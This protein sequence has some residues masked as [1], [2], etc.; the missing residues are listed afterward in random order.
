MSSVSNN[1]FQILYNDDFFEILQKS[2]N[3]PFRIIKNQNYQ[4]N[5]KKAGY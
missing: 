5:N 2:T 3:W 1:L 4:M